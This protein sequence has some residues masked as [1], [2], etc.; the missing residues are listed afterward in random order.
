[1]KQSALEEGNNNSYSQL[2]LAFH[3][4]PIF[5]TRILNTTRH[6]SLLLS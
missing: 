6:L 2:N 4:I 3:G 1:M 5:S